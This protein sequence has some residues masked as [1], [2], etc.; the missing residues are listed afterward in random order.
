V[1]DKND[2]PSHI[3]ASILGAIIGIIII[4][5]CLGAAYVVKGG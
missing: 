2:Q 4:A 1:T 3:L 5:S